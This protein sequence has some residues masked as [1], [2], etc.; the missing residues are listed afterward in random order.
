MT[1]MGFTLVEV[2]AA[3]LLLS[4]TI[5]GFITYAA[6]SIRYAVDAEH[7][8]KSTLLAEQELEKIK[9]TFRHAYD[10][11]VTAWSTALGNGYLISRSVTTLGALLKRISVSVGHDKDEDSVLDSDEIQITVT[12]QNAKLY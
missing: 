3:V 8:V 10:T 2:L 9:N 12:T 7:A 6:D 4:G 11:D 5:V 1:R